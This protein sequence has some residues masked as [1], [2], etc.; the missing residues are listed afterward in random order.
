MYS[1]GW[2]L[3]L[4]NHITILGLLWPIWS[5]CFPTLCSLNFLSVS[6]CFPYEPYLLLIEYFFWILLCF[7][8]EIASIRIF[9]GQMEG[10]F[11]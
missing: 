5:N 6:D 8:V 9:F 1:L 2:A 10:S 11:F 7:K 3:S 4:L